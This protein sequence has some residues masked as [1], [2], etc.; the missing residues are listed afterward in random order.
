M[1]M[2]LT[3]VMIL[4]L[5]LAWGTAWS[6]GPTEEQKTQIMDGLDAMAAGTASPVV[7]EQFVRTDVKAGEWAVVFGEY[8]NKRRFSPE[9]GGA[10]R[11]LLDPQ[12]PGIEQ[13]AQTAG[14]LAAEALRAAL[15]RSPA[16]AAEFDLALQWLEQMLPA[17]FSPMIGTGLG[18]VLSA[19]PIDPG[20]IGAAHAGGEVLPGLAAPGGIAGGISGDAIP[21]ATPPAAGAGS[22][23]GPVSGE[24]EQQP[25]PPAAA[26]NVPAAAI[27][28]ELPHVGPYAMQAAVTLGAYAGPAVGKWVAL[29][30]N[31]RII[32]ETGGVWVFDGGMM[33]E[34]QARSL[35]SLFR[36]LPP[37]MSGV[38]VVFVGID[39]VPLRAPGAITALPMLPPA[40]VRE[41]VAL[42][43]GAV[44]PPCPA[45]TA[46]MMDQLVRSLQDRETARRPELLL[47][48]DILLRM[49]A[50]RPDCALF[51]FLAAGGYGGPADFYPALAALW[52][53][54]SGAVLGAA[55]AL[56]A[57][58]GQEP[59]YALLLLADLLSGGGDTTP[60]FMVDGQGMVSGSAGALRKAMARPGMPYVTGVAAGGSV[61]EYDGLD[62]EMLLGM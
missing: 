41:P 42:P 14:M 47:R 56:V 24:S 1:R 22:P 6:A 3:R 57:Q 37:L 5:F 58:G 28:R 2:P 59:M 31:T 29:P 35:G 50:T 25:V 23:Q 21:P 33:S 54:D 19:K 48:R 15:G 26:R 18:A 40:M 34:P 46:M 17:P 53:C 20:G 11:V 52:L 38:S 30:L 44:L 9:L 4:P 7:M 45:V 10:L 43:T 62:Y 27:P 49:A 32:I 61:A 55:R 13:A 12:Q 60:L 8:W 36:S 16:D 39:P 51:P